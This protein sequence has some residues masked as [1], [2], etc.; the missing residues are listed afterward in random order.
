MGCASCRASSWQSVRKE[1]GPTAVLKAGMRR[2]RWIVPQVYSARKGTFPRWPNPSGCKLAAVRSAG[3]SRNPGSEG[4][5]RIRPHQRNC[6]DFLYANPQIYGIMALAAAAMDPEGRLLSARDPQGPYLRQPV[7]VPADPRP[8]RAAARRC[9]SGLFDRV[10][11]RE[12]A[13]R[14]DR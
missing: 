5:S 14:H 7:A 9:S 10:A 12:L 2:L 8:E 1:T 11:R 4:G 3:A 6:I 13:G